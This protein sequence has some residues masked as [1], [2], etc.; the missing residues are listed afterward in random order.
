M[1]P[2]ALAWA[3]ALLLA[4]ACYLGILILNWPFLAFLQ[5]QR[6]WGFFMQSCLFLW[7]DLFVSGLGVIHA[8]ATFVQGQA[9]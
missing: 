3:P 2:V 9:Y 5:R 8:L 6:G 4:L 1:L 7:P